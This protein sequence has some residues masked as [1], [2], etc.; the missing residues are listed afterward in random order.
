MPVDPKKKRIVLI[1][2]GVQSGDDA[3]MNQDVTI[4]QLITDRLNGMHLDFDTVMYKYENINDQ[5]QK[6]LRQVIGIFSQGL[7]AQKPIDMA[8]DVVLDV[9]IN[10]RNGKTAKAI[11]TGLK[12]KILEYYKAGNPLYIVAHSLGTVYSFDAVN[13]LMADKKLF[14][15]NDRKT[16]P[17]QGL[18]TLGSPLGLAMFKRTGVRKLGK[19]KYQFR[20]TNVLSR[21]DPVVTG[22]LYGKPMK[23]YTAVEKYTKKAN[24]WFI[25]DKVVDTGSVWL[26]AHVDYWPHGTIGDLLVDM[27]TH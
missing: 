6:R 13:E 15:P 12:N 22:S 17:V 19:G 8:A 14:K 18:V 4:R 25:M 7:H 2:H 24:N 21:T 26:I 10:L 23:G 5:A 1:V 16:W 3:G 27:V 11:R 9:L 20:W